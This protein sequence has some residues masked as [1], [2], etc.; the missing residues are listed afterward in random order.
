MTIWYDKKALED[1]NWNEE[2]LLSLEKYWDS[3]YLKVT[4]KNEI[5]HLIIQP[6]HPTEWRL[7]VSTLVGYEE[8]TFPIPEE[9]CRTIIKGMFI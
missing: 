3:L 6:T 9:L 8:W 2:K 5:K 7:N 4:F 1:E